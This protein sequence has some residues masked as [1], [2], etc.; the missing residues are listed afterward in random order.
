[1]TV[2]T[3]PRDEPR[4]APFKST[5]LILVGAKS[6]SVTSSFVLK[7]DWTSV[8]DLE[9]GTVRLTIKTTPARSASLRV[10]EV[11]RGGRVPSHE[12][13]APFQ[14]EFRRVLFSPRYPLECAVD[15]RLLSRVRFLGIRACL[16]TS[17]SLVRDADECC[18]YDAVSEIPL[19]KPRM[20]NTAGAEGTKGG[21]RPGLTDEFPIVPVID[22]RQEDSEEDDTS[23]SNPEISSRFSDKSAPIDSDKESSTSLS[24]KS[25]LDE[26]DGS[27]R[28][29]MAVSS[30]DPRC[31]EASVGADSSGE[32]D[33]GVATFDD[34]GSLRV[35]H[36]ATRGGDLGV[37]LP[38]TFGESTTEDCEVQSVDDSVV[39]EKIVRNLRKDVLATP[40]KDEEPDSE[41]SDVSSSALGNIPQSSPGC[42]KSSVSTEEGVVVSK[43]IVKT[44]EDTL[45]AAESG[46]DRADSQDSRKCLDEAPS[47]ESA[48]QVVGSDPTGSSVIDNSAAGSGSNKKVD[49]G[50]YIT[51]I[52][53]E[54]ERLVSKVEDEKGED[55]DIIPKNKD[56]VGELGDVKEE[57]GKKNDV[58]NELGDEKVEDGK[59]ND[60]VGELGDVKVEDGKKNDVVGE[61]GAANYDNRGVKRVE[62]VPGQFWEE[63]KNGNEDTAD[64]NGMKEDA[65]DKAVNRN[66]G[67]NSTEDSDGYDL[68]NDEDIN[69]KHRSKGNM[70]DETENEEDAEYLN[71]F[72][73][74]SNDQ[75]EARLAARRQ[76]RAEAREIR[77][78]ELERQQKEIE[79]NTNKSYDSFTAE[80]GNRTP[81]VAA[82]VN[83]SSSLLSGGGNNSYHSSRRSSEDSLEEGISL[84]D[85][86]HELKEVEDKF[87]KAMIQNAQLDN[88][89]ASLT[90]QV[91]LLKDRL[92]DLEESH[93][94]LQRENRDKCR[95]HDQL[96][97]ASAKLKEDME[98]YK[99]QLEERD[100]LIQ[101][102][103]LII[104]GDDQLSS[105][106]ESVGEDS[107][108][109][110]PKRALVS[111]ESAEMLETAGE[112]SLDVRLRRFA[113][114]RNELLDQ[115]RH[116]KL[117][118]EEERSRHKSDAKRI[119]GANLNGP[120]TDFEDIQREA[121]KLLGDYKFKLQ[122]AEQDVSTLQANVVRLESQVIRYKSAS[123]SSEKGEDELK[124]EKRKLQREV[125]ELTQQLSQAE[126]AK[127]ALTHQFDQLMLAKR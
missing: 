55:I 33:A 91:E 7:Y 57:D 50:N 12:G 65:V 44:V 16:L 5:C 66:D 122:K 69:N 63:S 93:S 21:G 39:E 71:N 53:K 62:N 46:C 34:E 41:V 123:E 113:E 75:A 61:L 120:D 80:P 125:R 59:K 40:P 38:D 126:A 83:R 64:I 51:D 90:Y 116:L 108:K 29:S 70:V 15:G 100:R 86:R 23:S 45:L 11:G 102:K 97:R 89:K 32:E 121:N 124:V 9:R 72:L 118:L 112:G 49:I 95:E 82:S 43:Y 37:N 96:K 73:G 26:R 74:K 119:P 3:S 88:E 98:W 111:I 58:V 68:E 17:S 105:E 85:V 101:E 79:E 84:R 35:D 36:A 99:A 117:E 47:E 18:F 107:P 92:E 25:D 115:V 28:L 81:R 127:A 87:R 24:D 54:E 27:G 77:M 109:K 76:A 4:R 10:M 60:V 52:S 48:N 78:R 94:Q 20:G 13:H 19:S 104:V 22:P 1:M 110:P 56:I 114:E 103:G 31:V 67:D 42:D 30:R 8:Y 106:D 2:V 14:A 6:L